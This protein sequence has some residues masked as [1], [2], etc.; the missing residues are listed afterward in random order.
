MIGFET[1]VG[2]IYNVKTGECGRRGR[3]EMTDM[4]VALIQAQFVDGD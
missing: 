2:D 1:Q 4:F 3:D